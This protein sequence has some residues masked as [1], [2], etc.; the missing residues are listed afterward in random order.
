MLVVNSYFKKTRS[1]VKLVC[2][3]TVASLQ[4][5]C[6]LILGKFLE[7]SVKSS[8]GE[9]FCLRVCPKVAVK[10]LALLQSFEVLTGTGNS[11]SMM[12]QAHGYGQEPQGLV[13]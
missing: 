11:A 5:L 13:V 12:A 6:S 7:G 10:M 4:F 3:P 1:Q 8:F 9:W 2:G